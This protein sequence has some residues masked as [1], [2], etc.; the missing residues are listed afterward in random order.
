MACGVGV[1]GAGTV[2]G[3]VIKTLL[4]NGEAVATRAGVPVTLTHVCELK[5]ECL[6]EF[7]LSGVAVTGNV[8]ELIADP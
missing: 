4:G 3:G 1:I 5:R 7:D 2:G 6:N 8:D